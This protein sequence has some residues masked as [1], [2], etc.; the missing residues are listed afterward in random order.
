MHFFNL[1][2]VLGHAQGAEALNA[3]VNLQSWFRT[4]DADNSGTIN[5]S[6]FLNAMRELKFE[7]ESKQMYN[8][9]L[10]F[11]NDGKDK[12]FLL[13]HVSITKFI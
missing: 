7:L 5:A 4:F 10:R 13:L 6:E 8:L 12:I 9:L 11:D 3:S 1:S 2:C